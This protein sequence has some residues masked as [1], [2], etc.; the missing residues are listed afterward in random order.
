[1]R[2]TYIIYGI[3]LVVLVLRYIVLNYI[4]VNPVVDV[5]KTGLSLRS[6]VKQIPL[7]SSIVV[8]SHFIKYVG[9]IYNVD[10]KYILQPVGK[11]LLKQNTTIDLIGAKARGTLFC[12]VLNGQW[13]FIASSDFGW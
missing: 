5:Q 8:D 1:M 2:R 9:G 13:D 12:S 11:C 4:L 3:L 10:D 6:F 7:G